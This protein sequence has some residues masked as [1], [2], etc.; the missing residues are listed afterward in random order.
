MPPCT[1]SARGHDAA[2]R[3]AE[4]RSSRSTPRP[5]V[6]VVGRRRRTSAAQY[7]ADA[8]ALDV[9]EHV[10]AAVLDRLEAA[11]RPAEL[12]A[13]LG[14]LHGLGDEGVD[15]A[16]RLG[17]LQHGGQRGSPGRAP[18]ANDAEPAGTVAASKRTSAKRRVRSKLVDRRTVTSSGR[19]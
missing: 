8:H 15:R 11:D 1:C 18:R 4:P 7:T 16:D 17:G 10:G 9:D 19:G 2:G 14:V 12:H 5:T 6:G 13:L 3:V